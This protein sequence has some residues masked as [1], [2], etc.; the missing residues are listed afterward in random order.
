LKLIFGEDLMASESLHKECGRPQYDIA[1]IAQLIEQDSKALKEVDDLGFLPLH[2]LLMN[3]SSSIADVLMMI[4]KYPAALN[5]SSRYGW[6]PLHIEC[7]TK[8]RSAI[9]SKC[10]QL[11]PEILSETNEGQCLPL[12]M[13]LSSKSS[14][15]E[16]ALMMIEKYPAAL[17]RRTDRFELP[18]DVEC[19]YKCRPAVLVKCIELYPELFDNPRM[20]NPIIRK[21]IA[22]VNKENFN[23]YSSVITKFFTCSPMSVYDRELY[24][25]GDI[26]DD[27][28]YFR[29][30]LNMLPRQTIS[31]SPTL[32]SD[33]RD[34]N[35]KSRA[36]TMMLLSKIKWDS[37]QSKTNPDTS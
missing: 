30:I 11:Y 17:Q 25:H 14:S 1:V 24:F 2:I 36:T 32:E 8:C 37:I 7:S 18:I 9:L 22:R 26:R 6:Y 12:H 5:H 4:E 31:T 21:F 10:I 35:W 28:Y 29:R 33:Y 23:S 13:L 34:L 27:P 16:D 15:V 19:T 3:E 20:S